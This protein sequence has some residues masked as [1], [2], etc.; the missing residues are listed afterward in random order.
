MN[1][2][3]PT[4]TAIPALLWHLLTWR[5]HGPLISLCDAI[6]LAHMLERLGTRTE[7]R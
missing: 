7:P 1:L 4:T 6:A 3:H 5:L 2:P